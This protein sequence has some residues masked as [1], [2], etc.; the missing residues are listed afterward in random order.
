MRRVSAA[1]AIREARQDDTTH[2]S[3]RA[4]TAPPCGHSADTGRCP[5]TRSPGGLFC[6]DAGRAV[7]TACTAAATLATRDSSH[8]TGTYQLSHGPMCDVGPGRRRSH[9]VSLFVHS[10]QLVAPSG[11]MH[12]TA[13]RAAV[14]IH[15]H[16]HPKR[17]KKRRE[18][19]TFAVGALAACLAFCHRCR[20]RRKACVGSTKRN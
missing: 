1:R 14:S 12:L 3:R 15:T 8:R 13:H 18:R 11:K 4:C 10:S 9:V 7:S 20:C 16:T 6:C 2:L 5:T 19:R 17:R